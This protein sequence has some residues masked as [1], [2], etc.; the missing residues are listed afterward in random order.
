MTYVQFEQVLRHFSAHPIFFDSATGDSTTLASSQSSAADGSEDDLSED[1]QRFAAFLD[2]LE[3]YFAHQW[4]R[5]VQK[6]RWARCLSVAEMWL[7]VS[8]HRRPEVLGSVAADLLGFVRGLL[9][10]GADCHMQGHRLVDA[11][12]L[13]TKAVFL[14]WHELE[15]MDGGVP[16]EGYVGLPQD[17]DGAASQLVAMLREL[18]RHPG[19]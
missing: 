5:H 18:L 16:A 19:L 9:L 2:T 8:L 7:I 11:V 6:M 4:P 12:K 14:C 1:V 15:A 10:V 17:G 3:G 13:A